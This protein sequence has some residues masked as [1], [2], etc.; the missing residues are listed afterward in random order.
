M[1]DQIADHYLSYGGPVFLLE[2]A[3]SLEAVAIFL[4]IKKNSNASVG[5]DFVQRIL[6]EAS[7]VSVR[8]SQVGECRETMADVP[9]DK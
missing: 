1:A 3:Y 9:A 7:K 6:L 4:V 2:A 5:R 8:L